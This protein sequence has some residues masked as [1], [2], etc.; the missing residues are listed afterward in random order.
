M[1]WRS[2]NRDKHR[3]KLIINQAKCYGAV[4]AAMSVLV[5]L[6]NARLYCTIYSTGMCRLVHQTQAIIISF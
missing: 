2:G 6:L 3:I 5:S 4:S 1:F